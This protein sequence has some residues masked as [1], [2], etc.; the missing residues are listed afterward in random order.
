M[1]INCS[2][3]SKITDVYAADAA[4]VDIAVKAARAAFVDSSWSEITPTSRGQLLYNLAELVDKHSEQ[5]AALETWNMGKPYSVSK[6]EDVA[7]SV[8]V[9]K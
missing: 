5:L 3:E 7:V 1:L 2:D 8:G 9:F 6:A 4:D